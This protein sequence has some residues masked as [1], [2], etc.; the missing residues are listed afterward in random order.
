MRRSKAVAIAWLVKAVETTA[1]ASTP[2]TMTSIRRKPRSGTDTNLSPTIAI[3]G[4]MKATR[5]CSPLR[6]I[7]RA[8]KLA[9]RRMRMPRAAAR[10][11]VTV[12]IA[13]PVR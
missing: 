9:C 13:R 4:R 2:G 1:R 7:V 8:S 10:R 5:S 12:V 3:A 11:P 6:S